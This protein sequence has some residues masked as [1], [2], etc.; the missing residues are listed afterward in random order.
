M[1]LRRRAVFTDLSR[2]RVF[3]SKRDVSLG[4]H[5]GLRGRLLVMTACATG[6]SHNANSARGVATPGRVTTKRGS[7]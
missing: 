6:F 7:R 4:Q 2:P 5:R 1:K 3:L